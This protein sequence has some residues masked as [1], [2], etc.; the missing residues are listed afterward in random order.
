MHIILLSGGSGKRLWPLSNGT[1]SKQFLKLLTTPDGE[2]ESMIQRVVR[3]IDEAQLNADITV[4]TAESQKDS[5]IAQL[6][7]SIKIVTEPERR[8]TFPAIALS[9][10]YLLMEES[11]SENEPIVVM[12][13]DSYVDSSYFEAIKKVAQRVDDNDAELVLIGIKPTDPSTKFGYL[14][15]E[16]SDASK[17]KSFVEKPDVN[18][19]EK[20][21][22]EGAVWNGGVF[23]FRLG[24]IKKIFENYV[25]ANNFQEFKSRYSELPKISFDYE[26]A[27]KAVSV[28]VVYYN[29]QWKDLGTWD[30]LSNELSD[31]AIGNC[32]NSDSTDTT[33][34]NELNIPIV[35]HHVDGLIIAASPDGILVAEKASSD[36]IKNAVQNIESRP[37][38]EERRW[39]SYKV[40][41]NIEFKDGFCALTKQLTLNPGCS[42]SYQRHKYRDEVWTFIDGEGEIAI[43]GLRRTVSRSDTVT[44]SKGQKHALKAI[45]PL[46]FIEVQRG[47]N[48]IEEDIELF[49]YEW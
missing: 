24:Y 1:R 2:K 6:G 9:C 47:S 49:Q 21:I 33:I 45:T 7:H 36:T 25:T 31:N 32:T 4:A 48:L 38:Y 13:C 19:A 18:K 27:E 14:L 37:M 28:G 41:D 35:C 34:I 22:S 46:T 40:I 39:G 12:P 43:D 44:I 42:I 30:T 17:V 3:Q 20:L 29:G 23:G 8:D 26:V 15:P 5:I 11:L 16:T 10:A